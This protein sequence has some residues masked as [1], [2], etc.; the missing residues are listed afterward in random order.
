MAPLFAVIIQLYRTATEC[1][2]T[3]VPDSTTHIAII[4]ITIAVGIACVGIAC[5]TTA[6]HTTG[7]II[8]GTDGDT[9]HPATEEC[10]LLQ[11]YVV[12]LYK[13]RCHR[14]LSQK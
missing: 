5:I 1:P 11:F 3:I 13:R 8:R 9:G 12:F 14:K 6:V 4:G 2:T 7:T 10:K